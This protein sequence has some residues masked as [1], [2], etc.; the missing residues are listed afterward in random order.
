[1][2]KKQDVKITRTEQFLKLFSCINVKTL[3]AIKNDDTIMQRVLIAEYLLKVAK[4][5]NLLT[6]VKATATLR[7]DLFSMIQDKDAV[8]SKKFFSKEKLNDKISKQECIASIKK[9]VKAKAIFSS[10]YSKNKNVISLLK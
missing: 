2:T 9:S 5:N 1:M 8:K 6:S 4:E 10:M 7:E 3:K